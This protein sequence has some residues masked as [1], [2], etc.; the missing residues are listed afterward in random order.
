MVTINWCWSS[1]TCVGYSLLLGL[2]FIYYC[3]LIFLHISKEQER[4]SKGVFIGILQF[5]SSQ[6]ASHYLG[7]GIFTKDWAL[8][9]KG[10]KHK[11]VRR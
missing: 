1:V 7:I 9:K 11:L 5:T 2:Y 8:H 4:Y 10:K 6:G 3:V